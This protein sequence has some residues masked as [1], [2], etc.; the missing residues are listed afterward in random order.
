VF[1][2]PALQVVMLRFR[3]G[4]TIDSHATPHH[5]D[6]VCLEGS[7]FVSFSSEQAPFRGGH[8]LRWPAGAVHGLWTAGSE[9]TVMLL[10][11]VGPGSGL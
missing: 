9:M 4:A 2:G 6:A 1:S 8:S 7:G 10:E 3:P 11:H 5:I